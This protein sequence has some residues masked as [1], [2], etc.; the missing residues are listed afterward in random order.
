ARAEVRP[1]PADVR[2]ARVL[3]EVRRAS[4][5]FGDRVAEAVLEEER[6]LLLGQVSRS[7]A[8]DVAYVTAV[9]RDGVVQRNRLLAPWTRRLRHMFRGVDRTISHTPRSST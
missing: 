6:A 3:P 4:G 8:V 1:A 5:A 2:G 7:S 9:E